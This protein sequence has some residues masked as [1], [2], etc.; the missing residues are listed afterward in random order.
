MKESAIA[1]LDIIFDPNASTNECES[2]AS[3]LVEIVHPEIMDKATADLQA[4][5]ESD[6]GDVISEALDEFI[7]ANPMPQIETD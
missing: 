1:M 4:E 5:W 2:A 7:S 6:C 3:T